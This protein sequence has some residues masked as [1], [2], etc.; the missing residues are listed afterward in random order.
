[1]KGSALTAAVIEELGAAFMGALRDAG[2]ALA[3]A[4]FDGVEQQVQALARRVMGRV[5]E[6]ALAERAAT[7]P[8]EAPCCAHCGQPQR[9]VGKTR[10]REL[11]GLVGDY[12]LR[13]AYYYCDHCKQGQAPF[14]VQV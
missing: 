3:A 8:A 12:V 14:D 6:A 5:V 4:D 1:M 9:L 7:L 2:P 13:R 11:H 10:T